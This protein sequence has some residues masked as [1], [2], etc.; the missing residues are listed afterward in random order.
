MFRSIVSPYWLIVSVYCST[1][2]LDGVMPLS[3]LVFAVGAIGDVTG[4]FRPLRVLVIVSPMRLGN[5]S[6]SAIDLKPR[7][8][9]RPS[10]NSR[11]RK[12][13]WMIG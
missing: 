2:Q 9:C 10:W 4:A 3:K 6:R 11:A 7:R 5:T 8:D 1:V 13:C 12:P